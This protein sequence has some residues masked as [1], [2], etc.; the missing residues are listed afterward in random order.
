MIREERDP[1]WWQAVADHPEVAPNIY[2]GQRFDTAPVVTSPR[3]VPLA[4]EHGG[5]WFFD[6]PVYELHAL[7]TPEGWG[8]EVAQAL[9]AA[10][11]W[12]IARGAQGFRTLEVAG[13]AT[14]RPPRSHGWRPVGSFHA[15]PLGLLVRDWTLSLDGYRRSPAYRRM[16]QCRQS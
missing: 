11:A 1:A 16:A 14:S 7:F 6:G 15:G 10:M 2:L 13:L 9:K 12:M 8:R 5:F 3:V 4:A